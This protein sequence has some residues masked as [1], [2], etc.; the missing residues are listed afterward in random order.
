MCGQTLLF[1]VTANCA[2]HTA[3]YV[4]SESKKRVV[5]DLACADRVKPGVA[6]WGDACLLAALQV[7][8]Y[9]LARELVDHT[10]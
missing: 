3:P 10:Q 9:L 2:I 1:I 4:T 6:D 8:S 5:A 7:P